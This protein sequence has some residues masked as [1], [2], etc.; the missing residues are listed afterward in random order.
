MCEIILRFHDI[1]SREAMEKRK[2]G[3]SSNPGPNIEVQ[4]VCDF[5][6]LIRKTC[7]DLD[8]SNRDSQASY[9]ANRLRTAFRVMKT[10]MIPLSLHRQL[11]FESEN[12]DR[13]LS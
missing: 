1:R 8:I 2:T 11:R 10:A 7:K 13:C 6:K 4:S 12:S 9:C 5:S 3:V